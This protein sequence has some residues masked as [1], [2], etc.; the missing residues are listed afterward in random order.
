MNF[1]RNAL[2]KHVDWIRSRITPHV[3]QKS[4]VGTM[5]GITV[6]S[7]DVNFILILEEC[8]RGPDPMYK[9]KSPLFNGVDR[10]VCD[11]LYI[12][13][14]D[15]LS[16]L[17]SGLRG[18][19]NVAVLV[20]A[21]LPICPEHITDLNRSLLPTYHT[22]NQAL[23]FH[24]GTRDLITGLSGERLDLDSYFTSRSCM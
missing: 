3:R 16:M 17:E 14:S 19:L 20:D 23:A 12:V 6:L 15:E 1:N 7:D 18:R 21:R 24:V 11:Y 22:V 13:G 2:Q 8:F 10:S 9:S 5:L 4:I